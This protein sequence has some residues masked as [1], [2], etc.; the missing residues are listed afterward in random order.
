MK[1]QD[2]IEGRTVLGDEERIMG[3]M[4]LY[5]WAYIPI[6]MIRENHYPI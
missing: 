4:K 6:Y 2:R 3:D 5:M 1:S